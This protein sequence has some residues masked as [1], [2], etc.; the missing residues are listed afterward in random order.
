MTNKKSIEDMNFQ[1]LMDE[2]RDREIPYKDASNA[3]ELRKRLAP[4]K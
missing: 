3:D 4:K 1:E 2:C